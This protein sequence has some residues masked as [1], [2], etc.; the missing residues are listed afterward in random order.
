VSCDGI[1]VLVKCG[2]KHK[3]ENKAIKIKISVSNSTRLQQRVPAIFYE[4]FFYL[5][6][7]N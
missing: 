7:T 4:W 5:Q 2:K 3:N 6:E 1:K